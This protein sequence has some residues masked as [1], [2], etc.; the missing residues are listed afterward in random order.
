MFFPVELFFL[1]EDTGIT[2]R[3]LCYC[4]VLMFNFVRAELLAH[5]LKVLLLFLSSVLLHALMRVLVLY[6]Y[7]LVWFEHSL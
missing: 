2:N 3:S 6:L 7:I 4:W 1:L 5:I